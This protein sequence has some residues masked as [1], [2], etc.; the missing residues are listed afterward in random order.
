MNK[1]QRI[2]LTGVTGYVGGRLLARLEESG[3]K[4]RCMVRDPARVTGRSGP[5]TE[6]VQGDIF[7]SDSLDRALQGI[8]TAYY[9]VHSMAACKDFAQAD[10]EG[11]ERFAQAARK[12][13]VERIIY[14]GGLAHSDEKLSKHLRSR[15]E[16]G[17]VLRGSGVDVTEFRASIIIGS[18]S[19]SFELIRALMERLPIMVMPR[20]VSMVAQPIAIN[21][22]VQ[23]LTEVLNRKASGHETFEIGGQDQVSYGEIMREYARQRGL[24]R[25]MI[26]IPV[27]TPRLS[28]LWLGLVT[29]LYARVGRILINSIR[30]ASVVKDT[31]ARREFDI[32]PMTLSQAVAAALSGE[33]EQMGLAHWSNALSA[34]AAPKEWGGVRFGNRLVD[35]RMRQSTLSPEEVWPF[36]SC[37]GGRNGWYYGN[38]L[39]RIRG[40]IDLVLGGVGMRRARRH[41]IW[42]QTGDI[43]DCWRVEKAQPDHLLRLRAEMK[44]PGRAWLT[45]EIKKTPSGCELWQT[46]EFD[47]V[48]LFG[49]VYWYSLYPLHE[50][51]FAG[52]L[53]GI[54]SAASKARDERKLAPARQPG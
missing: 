14:L 24:K 21:D 13:G 1:N 51:I 37:I 43:I 39:W 28:S 45:F 30:N 15:Q 11:A 6:V 29:P 17:E 4:V 3:Y 50:F 12:A 35:S 32:S 38:L 19:L 47:P 7:D 53:K 25:W 49:L 33:D 34:S 36:I 2:L 40:W 8:T 22:V 9:L 31:S 23:Y 16:V 5:G 44:L 48:G 20:W 54:L 26:P 27:L 42:I 52:M 46:A 10:R 18:G 41:P